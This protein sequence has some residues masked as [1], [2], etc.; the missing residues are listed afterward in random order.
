MQYDTRDTFVVDAD[1]LLPSCRRWEDE[2]RLLLLQ[3]LV[4]L[5]VRG[6]QRLESYAGMIVEILSYIVKRIVSKY[7]AMLFN[8]L[9][10]MF[11]RPMEWSHTRTWTVQSGRRNQSISLMSTAIQ[12]LVQY[13]TTVISTVDC[14]AQSTIYLSVGREVLP[15]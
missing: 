5:Y 13:S 8:R 9:N 6:R 3:S 2:D 7:L 15:T 10:V 14:S 1:R 11:W 4:V 12:S